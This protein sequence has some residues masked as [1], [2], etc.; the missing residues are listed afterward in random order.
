MLPE[1]RLYSFIDN[2]NGFTVHFF[3]GQKLIHDLAM[4][5]NLKGKG[6]AY[7]RD[8]ILTSQHMVTFLKPGEGFGFFIDSDEPYFRLKL[9]FNYSGKMR[10]LLLPENFNLFPESITGICRLS[11]LFPNNS[12][13][14][15]SIIELDKIGLNKVVSKVF[16]DS[17]Q[18]NS[19]IKLSE[20]S[21]QSAMIMKLPELN[22]NKEQIVQSLS[23]NEYWLTIQKEVNEIFDKSSTDQLEIQQSF[24]K[25]GLELLQSKEINFD[26]NCTQDRMLRGIAGLCASTPI[27]DIFEDDSQ[28]ETR[29]DYCKTNYIITKDQVLDKVAVLKK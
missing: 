29:C 21:D 22:V 24:E 14:Y 11:K 6:F 12:Q 28:I 23:L 15:N 8:S 5:H 9:E 17:Y 27:D 13:P 10:T 20:N 4:I 3:E 19:D 2:K 26:C 16:S 25:L 7:F 1:S 18:L